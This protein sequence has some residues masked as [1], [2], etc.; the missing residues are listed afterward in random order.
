MYKRVKTKKIKVG[1]MYIGG[2]APVS[3]QTMTNTKTSDVFATVRQILSAEKAGCDLVRV[4]VPDKESAMAISKIK[5]RI[6]VPLIADIHFDYKLALLSMEQGIDKLRINPGN[7]GGDDKVAKVVALAK[8]KKIPIRIGVNM[9]SLEKEIEKKYGMTSRAMVESAMRH[10]KILEKHGFRDIL[11]ALKA[12]DVI[13]TVE[14]Y[15]MLSK[16]VNYPLHLGITEAGNVFSG[17]VKSAVGLGSLLLDGIGDTIRV[18]LTGPIKEEVRVGKEI[19]KSL[20]IRQYGPEII[21]CPTCAR[22]SIDV[23][24][25]SKEVEKALKGIK[26]PIK[27]AVMG[28]VVNG[29]GESKEADFGVTGTNSYGII[30]AH[31]KMVKK[32]DKKRIVSEL[33]KLIG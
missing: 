6:H 11:I 29:P 23:E 13:R 30:Y 27:V 15:K 14:A 24:K 22:K 12:S 25:L 31:G 10:I 8:K 17:T 5:K 7:I 33:L 18:S 32:V 3:V 9:G 26:K 28:C 16:K 2:D 19:L 4:A 1:S 21:S 20:G